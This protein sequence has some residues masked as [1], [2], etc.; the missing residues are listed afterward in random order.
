MLKQLF[1]L[2]FSTVMLLAQNVDVLESRY[3]LDPS[4]QYSVEALHGDPSL[5]TQTLTSDTTLGFRE[6]AVWIYLKLADRTLLEEAHVVQFIYPLHDHI[7]VHKFLHGKKVESYSTGDKTP[8]ETRKLKS[9]EFAIP[10][11]IPKGETLEI[12]FKIDSQSSLNIGIDHMT[13]EAY[14]YKETRKI[15][16]LSSYYGAVLIMVLYNLILYFMI[17]EKIYRHYVEF[18]FANLFLQLGLNGLGFQ[19]IYPELPQL[20]SYFIPV[21]YALTNYYA[22]IF[23]VS[24][25]RINDLLPRGSAWLSLF[26]WLS[27]LFVLLSFIAPYVFVIKGITVLSLISAIWLFLTSIYIC[28][29]YGSSESKFFLTAWGIFLTG[30]MIEEAMY[31]GLV[32]MNN[33]S[34]HAA[35]IG[36]LVELALFSFALAYRYNTVF[37]KLQKTKDDL[38]SLNKDLEKRVMESIENLHDKHHQ[39]TLEVENKKILLRE[40]YH[41][42]KN[43]LQI[44]TGLLSLQV[45]RMV[46]SPT[47]RMFDETIQHIKAMAILHEKLYQLDDMNDV[48]MQTYIQSLVDDLQQSFSLE[49]L[50]CEIDCNTIHLDLEMAVPIGLIINEVISNT[51][52]YAFKEG[53]KNKAIALTL[54]AAESG[55]M[56]LKIGDNGQGADRERLE[57]GF[58]FKLIQTL[59]S[60]QLKGEFETV[61]RQGLYYEIMFY[62]TTFHRPRRSTHGVS[63]K[64]K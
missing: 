36:A 48:D 18:H 17:R 5:F 34:L 47:K 12:I 24:F 2:L 15:F 14:Y 43:N 4:H 1:L 29:R 58:G 61:N 33:F 62:T 53:E 10:Y 27:L 20:N 64:L 25:L 52:K 42:V 51:F 50:Q 9:H 26:A 22:I 38:R 46:E 30:A 32:P 59:V 7:E 40:I 28:R 8:F 19:Y 55:K 16:V 6:D 21:I 57:K 54:L 3:F 49:D 23:S 45:M 56:H 31:L 39:L 60:N 41:R 37:V 11:T 63:A 35:Q 13:Q 44:M